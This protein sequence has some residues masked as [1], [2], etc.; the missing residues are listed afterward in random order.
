MILTDYYKFVHLPDS[1]KT[2]RDC[3]ASTKTYPD[4]EALRNKAEKLF[5]YFGDVPAQF[6]GDVHRKADKAITKTKSISSV[7]VPDVNLTFAHGDIRGTN[8][9][10]LIIFDADYTTLEIFVAR[11]QKNTRHNLWQM[12]AAGELDD[13]ISELRTRA[14]TELVTDK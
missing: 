12:L 7:F 13:E 11:G 1:S 9:A 10:I 2:R 4:F 8:D 5:V 6:G 14:V 3:T